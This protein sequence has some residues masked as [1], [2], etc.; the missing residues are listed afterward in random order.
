MPHALPDTLQRR[1]A[2][3]AGRRAY[4]FLDEHGQEQS[5]LTYGDLHARALAVASRLRQLCRPGDRAVLLFPPGLDFIVAYFGCLYAQVI[6]V[7]VS[8]PRPNRVQEATRSIIT[9]CRPTAVLTTATTMAAAK[10]LLEAVSSAAH[11]VPVDDLAEDPGFVPEPASLDSTAFLQYTSGSTAAPK[12][13]MVSHRNLVANQEM[14]QHAFGHDEHS[15]FVGWT[16]L[17]HD[18]GLIGNVL[19]PLH[20]GV[21]SVLMAPGAFIR[22]P[23]NWLSA[24]SQYRAHTSG[25][26]NFAFDACIAHAERAGV[27]ADLDLSSWKVAF[28]GA[29]PLRHDTLRRFAETFAP[30]GFS[31]SALYPCY[32][33]AEATLLSTGS[34]KGRGPRTV[35]ADVDALG[36]RRFVAA[37]PGQGRTLVGSGL[38]P[39]TGDVRIVDP[40]TRHPCSADEIGE[41]W[42]SGNHVATGYWERPE[43]TEQTLRA[44]CE[45][46][47]ER[48]YLRTGDLGV[49]IDDELY[50]VCR[51]KDVIIIRGRNHYPQ[52]IEHTA[53]SAHPALQPTSC[54]A[55][56]IDGPGGEKLVVVQELKRD[57]TDVDVA[58][59]LASIR[60]AIV[61]EHELSP[62]DVVLAAPG[63]LSKTTSGK[64]MRGAAKERYLESGFEAWQ[65]SAALA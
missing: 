22:R 59:V 6:A 15:T 54:A 28:N 23:L 32:G 24:I 10:P 1:S 39:T 43:L 48:V 33:S 65:P 18:Q 26:P 31:P 51:L 38:L 17:H 4:V 46:V 64:I 40:E 50:V 7:P 42:I 29:E 9:D 27:G 34:R 41:I 16:P 58:E 19:Q 2:A 8:P 13:V 62:G 52:D 57:A 37:V 11:W 25:G 5:V 44:R 53:Q 63:Q 14:I 47:D 21:T 55:F 12:G 36:R 30:F 60:R 45:G 20:L 61:Q 49:V 3:D 56:A 35:E